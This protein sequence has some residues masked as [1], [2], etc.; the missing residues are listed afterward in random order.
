MTKQM[1]LK[2]L[3]EALEN[4]LSGQIVEDNVNYYS[5]YISDEVRGG[6]SEEDVVGGLGD[7]WVIARNIIDSPGGAA[8]QTE[9][10][11]TIDER[12]GAQSS[13][14]TYRSAPFDTWWKKLL[15]VLTVVM[16]V[17]I[18][19]AIVTGVVSLLAPIVIP[20]LIIMVIVRA[21]GGRS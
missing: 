5:N 6:Q 10:Y 12:D 18:V 16:V 3:R 14:E 19:V 20:V 2:E 4:D 15:A 21:I 13:S 17:V 9:A 8:S 11:E 1:F 7:P